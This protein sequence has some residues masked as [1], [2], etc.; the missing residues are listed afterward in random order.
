MVRI[1]AHAGEH[2]IAL[3]ERAKVEARV[4]GR[5]VIIVQNGITMTVYPESH[6][7][8]SLEIHEL[9]R[10]LNCIVEGMKR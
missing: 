3:I 1:E 8:D 9:K 7:N 5:P 10:Q 4:F 6:L 2:I